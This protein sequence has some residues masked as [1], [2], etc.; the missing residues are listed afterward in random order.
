M[1]AIYKDYGF[2]KIDVQYVKY[3]NSLDSQV[4]YENSLN[5]DRKPYLG[6]I[7]H[8]G[9]Y[10]YCIP[11]TSSKKRHL[12]WKNVTE[13]NYLIYEIIQ[14]SEIH[15]NDIYKQIANTNQFKKILAVLEIRKMIPVD[16]TVCEHIDFTSIQDLKYKDLLEK[17]YNFLKPLRL[18]I[19]KR[20]DVLYNKQIESGQ[21]GIGICY[22]NFNILENGF[23]EYKDK[24]G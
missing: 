10:N 2:Y 7:L 4:Y 3:L 17:E 11:I 20:A 9:K 15:L 19:L 12:A 13:H 24:K 8:L 16:D 23:C 1:E 5:Y 21:I 6:L 22:C 14:Q 18:D